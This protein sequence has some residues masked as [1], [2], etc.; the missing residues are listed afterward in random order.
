MDLQTIRDF[1]FGESMK[2]HINGASGRCDWCLGITQLDECPAVANRSKARAIRQ[3]NLNEVQAPPPPT[4]LP[5]LGDYTEQLLSG[6]GITKDLWLEVKEKHGLAPT[7]DCDL[8]KEWLN[9]VGAYFGIG[10]SNGE[11]I[12]TGVH[13]SSGGRADDDGAGAGSEAIAR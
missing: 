9:K 6:I 11:E 10:K 12:H 7:C 4:P 2:C 5:G 3:A 1:G 13:P 8:R